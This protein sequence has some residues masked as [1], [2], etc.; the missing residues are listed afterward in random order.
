MVLGL[1]KQEGP[2]ATYKLLMPISQP[3]P[4]SFSAF[5]FNIV[6]VILLKYSCDHV[7]WLKILNDFSMSITELRADVFP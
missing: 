2:M 7:A 4:N 3:K 1:Q 6:M 5:K